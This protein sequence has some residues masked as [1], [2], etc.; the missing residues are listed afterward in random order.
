MLP[1]RSRLVR[2]RRR[3][4]ATD[5][6]LLRKSHQVDSPLADRV[7]LGASAAANKSK[8][9]FASAALLALLG[10]R[11]GRRAARRGALAIGLTS[12]VVNGPLKLLLRR[13]RPPAN[14]VA[15]RPNLLVAPASFS[16]PSGHSA[17]A[18]AFATSVAAE[19]P[20]AAAPAFLAASVVGYSR[21]HTGVHF[22]GDVLAGAGLGVMAAVAAGRILGEG[23][24]LSLP[25]PERAEFPHRVVLLTSPNS[26]SAELLHEAKR[27]MDKFGLEVLAEI[28]VA[29][30]EEL[31]GWVDQD[32]RPLIVAAGGDG[33]IGAAA[34]WVAGT[35]ALLGI[36][37]LGTSNDVARSLGIPLDPA[38]A[39]QILRDGV[40]RTIDAGRLRLADGHQRYFVHAATVG[41]NVRF[42]QLA[43]KSSI[44]RRFG[45]F[46]Y[47]VAASRAIRDHEPFECELHYGEHVEKLMLAQLSII[48]AP[49]FGGSLDLRIP[50]AR[51]DDRHLIVIAVEEKPWWQLLGGAALTVAGGRRHAG[52][53]HAMRVPNLRVHVDRPLDVALDGEISASVPADFEIAP[54]ALRVLTPFDPDL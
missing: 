9:W 4:A 17:S 45:R 32:D 33:T 46:T 10:G 35:G 28:P 36:L 7:L 47:A 52:G 1:H 14:V 30:S 16:F 23:Q 50:G 51:V 31:A 18:F 15:R 25:P 34:G 39:A 2:T 5:L 37:P 26:G 3:V 13:G 29:R 53:V 24:P 44:R 22:P 27:A 41:F 42:A 20:P 11:R 12:S 38:Q 21:V 54:A 48:N 49:I 19:L 6:W 8:V 43:T 40:A